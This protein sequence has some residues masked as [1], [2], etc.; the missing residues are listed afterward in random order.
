MFDRAMPRYENR[1]LSVLVSDKEGI[2]IIF[3]FQFRCRNHRCIMRS[4]KCDKTNDCGDGSDEDPKD[5]KV[6]PQCTKGSLIFSS[7][8]LTLI[9]SFCIL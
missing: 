4:R 7:F 9:L 8:T 5:C 1:N 3:S 2:F 6:V